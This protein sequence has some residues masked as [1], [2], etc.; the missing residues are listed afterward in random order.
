MEKL[1]ITKVTTIPTTLKENTIYLH[2]NGSGLDMYVTDK[3]ATELIKTNVSKD[4][5]VTYN[6]TDNFDYYYY[7]GHINNF[8]QI[9]RWDIN[10]GIKSTASLSN[11]LLIETLEQAWVNKH[12][13]TYT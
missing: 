9:N 10:T 2:K 3:N 6:D 8:W 4:M 13:L 12:T 7:G 5:V 1:Y 11:N